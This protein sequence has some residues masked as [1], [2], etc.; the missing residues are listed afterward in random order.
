MRTT[1]TIYGP[2]WDPYRMRRPR[3]PSS[4]SKSMGEREFVLQRPRHRR[5]RRLAFT[6]EGHL[7]YVDKSKW[8]EKGGKGGFNVLLP[9][10]PPTPPLWKEPPSPPSFL[11][12][13]PQK[14][15]V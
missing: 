13:S 9:L 8:G 7:V 5:R 4:A 10:S 6:A 14:K 1:E 3:R 11:S 2:T 15:H 12:F